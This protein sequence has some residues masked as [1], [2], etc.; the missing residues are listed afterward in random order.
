MKALSVKQPFASLI[1]TGVKSIEIR[2]WKTNYRGPLLICSGRSLHSIRPIAVEGLPRGVTICTVELAD[3]RPLTREDCVLGC[4]PWGPER[5][6]E[7]AWVL[8]NPV[9]TKHIPIAGKLGL[10]QVD[11]SQLDLFGSES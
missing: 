4:V 2:S 11:E 5:E 10:F 1:S 6:G 3:C 7:F 9:P 8:K